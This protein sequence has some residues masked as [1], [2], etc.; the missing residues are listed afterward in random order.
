MVSCIV[1]STVTLRVDHWRIGTVVQQMLQ[2]TGNN[3]K[4]HLTA[5][6]HNTSSIKKKIIGFV[7]QSDYTLGLAEQGLTSTT[8][9]LHLHCSDG[10]RK[11]DD[12][13]WKGAKMFWCRTITNECIVTNLTFLLVK[14]LMW[15]PKHQENNLTGNFLSAS[16]TRG[17]AKEELF[18][19]AEGL[20]GGTVVQGSAARLVRLIDL[21]ASV[22]QG[23]GA[24]VPPISSRVVQRCS[25]RR[26]QGREELKVRRNR[27]CTNL[28]E[29]EP[30]VTSNR[31]LTFPLSPSYSSRYHYLRASS[32][33]Q[34]FC[35]DRR[36]RKLSFES[37][38]VLKIKHL[39]I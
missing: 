25:A 15:E 8:P 38:F 23:H 34:H 32:D 29:K 10:C 27:T 6:L 24:L 7:S 9:L 3:E 22:H 37:R 26:G 39:V 2:A 16:C 1:N 19:P 35:E 28:R 33:I 36:F 4:I 31:A 17:G 13:L 5:A 21:S 14:L 11:N 30:R 12:Q 20:G 18:K